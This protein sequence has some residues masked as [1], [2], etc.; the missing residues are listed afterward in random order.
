M[1]ATTTKTAK[2]LQLLKALIDHPRTSEEERDAARR[3]LKRT[4]D[5]AAAG[6]EKPTATGW[7][8][9]RTYGAK[10]QQVRGLR[11]AE[12]AKL[13][14]ADIKLARKIGLKAAEPGAIAI[15]DPIAEAP[16][17][18][19]FSVTTQMYSGGGS[20]DITI[21][22]IP[23]DWGYTEE[24][25]G[26]HIR[27]IPTPALKDLADELAAIH[28]AYNYNGSDITTDYFD[29]NYYGGVRDEHSLSL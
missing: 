6:G 9:H 11:L 2:K 24:D 21:K 16:T 19:K 4:L 26:D 15:P 10:Y 29:V 12:I 8:D 3:M 27:K 20:I 22:N 14:R 18:I 17:G 7:V 13:M 5:K 28:R 1:N 23:A 25:H